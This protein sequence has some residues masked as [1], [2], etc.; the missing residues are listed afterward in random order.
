MMGVGRQ[1]GDIVRFACEPGFRMFGEQELLCLQSGQWNFP[2]PSCQSNIFS[3]TSLP[4]T[5]LK[6]HKAIV[7]R[8][9]NRICVK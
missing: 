9:S 3:K 8:L 7:Q 6:I 2:P 1:F 4:N 5:I